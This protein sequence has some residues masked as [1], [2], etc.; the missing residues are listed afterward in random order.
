MVESPPLVSVIVPCHNR[1]NFLYEC[2]VSVAN[3][4]HK[5]IEMIVIDDNSEDNTIDEQGIHV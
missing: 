3:Q 1:S 4:S 5:N 2:L